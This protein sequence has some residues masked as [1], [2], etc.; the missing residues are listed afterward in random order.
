VGVVG[1]AALVAMLAF[2][3]ML[4]TMLLFEEHYIYFP[5]AEIGRT[6]A[7]I[8]LGFTE[9]RFRTADGLLLHGWYIPAAG[10][11][12]TLLHFHGNAGNISHR[13]P[14]YRQWHDLGLSVFAFDYRGYGRSEGK[15]SEEG[16]QRD[17][18]AAW[19]ALSAIDGFSAGRTLLAG[20]SLGAAV[21]AG[22]A[23]EVGA[24][25]LALE[26]PFTNVSEM[27]EHHYPWLPLRWLARSRF[28]TLAAVS[29][30]HIPLLLISAEDDQ[31]VPAGMAERILAAAN[32]PKR[33]IQLPGGHNDFDMGP[34]DGYRQAWLAWLDSLPGRPAVQ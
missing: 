21:A 34:N 20:R 28:D 24:A 8:G 25:G 9:Q 14:L 4:G 7:D 22:L 6:P 19:Q 33:H 26:T 31:I 30:V 23:S 18:R 3:G 29:R 13:L 15:P 12:L 2:G 16:L 11:R 17:A 1:S 5:E 10:S 27:A 32:A